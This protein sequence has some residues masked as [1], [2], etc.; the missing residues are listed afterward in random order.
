[1]GESE[2]EIGNEETQEIPHIEKGKGNPQDDDE[3]NVKQKAEQSQSSMGR[4]EERSW[5]PADVLD[6]ADGL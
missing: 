4:N 3:G 6:S 2:K 1:M 5:R